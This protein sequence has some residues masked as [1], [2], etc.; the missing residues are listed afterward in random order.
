MN[1]VKVV[2]RAAVVVEEAFSEF[3]ELAVVPPPPFG[4][5]LPR[6]CRG[7]SL[8]TIVMLDDWTVVMEGVMYLILDLVRGMFCVEY[9]TNDD[10]SAEKWS[11][12]S[13][14]CA[15]ARL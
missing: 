1:S 12:E 15:A 6:E 13:G 7:E 4:V 2:E 10:E 11:V 5:N 14:A 8:V 9:R 3:T